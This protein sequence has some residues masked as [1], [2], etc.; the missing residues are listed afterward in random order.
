MTRERAEE[1][2][3]PFAPLA[4][5]CSQGKC[6]RKVFQWNE[7]DAEF[8]EK[9][10]HLSSK[11]GM[12]TTQVWRG[13][14]TKAK[15]RLYVGG[16]AEAKLGSPCL[17]PASS[18]VGP[19]RGNEQRQ[20]RLDVAPAVEPELCLRLAPVQ[21]ARE[22]ELLPGMTAHAHFWGIVSFSERNGVND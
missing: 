4:A 3:V 14:K 10:L 12:V 9:E 17:W 8:L 16:R 6:T 21:T 20:A 11:S 7:K 13:S 15:L 5:V 18:P 1:T 19:G 22:P 2:C